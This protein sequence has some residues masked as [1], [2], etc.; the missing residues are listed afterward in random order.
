[1]KNIVIIFLLAMPTMAFSQTQ[2]ALNATAAD[3]YRDSDKA[4]NYIYKSVLKAQAKDAAFIKSIKAA[5]KAWIVFRDAEMLAKF[6][7]KDEAM[8]YGSMF[9]LEW[10]SALKE[11]TDK[12]TKELKV[13]L[14]ADE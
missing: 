14:K 10:N 9:G 13:Y 5:Q 3:N 11:L 6:P 7:H 2:S 1:M 12:R 8:Y 4:L